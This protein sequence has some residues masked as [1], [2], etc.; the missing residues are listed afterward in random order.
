VHD[1]KELAKECSRVWKLSRS[2]GKSITMSAVMAQVLEKHSL[3][4]VPNIR[5]DIGKELNKMRQA[6]RQ[7]DKETEKH[8]EAEAAYL[9]ALIEEH[10]QDP[11]VQHFLSGAG[12]DDTEPWQDATDKAS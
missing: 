11:N 10:L 8:L 6:A 4:F 2:K 12:D 7:R 3:R 1:I 9:Q 5:R